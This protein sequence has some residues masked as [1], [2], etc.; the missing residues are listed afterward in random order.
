[1]GRHRLINIKST[2]LLL[3]LTVLMLLLASCG[4]GIQIANTPTF[5]VKDLAKVEVE[6]TPNATPTSTPTP[7]PLTTVIYT[8]VASTPRS[9]A[10]PHVQPP[11]T[12]VEASSEGN[13]LVISFSPETEARYRV[14]EQLAR[15]NLPNDAV[16]VTNAVT[17]VVTFDV[18]GKVVP[19]DSKIT[20]DASA[21]KSDEDRRDNRV[22]KDILQTNQFP[23]IDFVIK[24]TPGL[25]WPLL[26][27]GEGL[28]ELVGDLTIRDVTKEVTW[29]V[30]ATFISDRIRGLA[31]T[32]FTFDDF[33]ISKP[34][35]MFILSVEDLIRLEL[36]FVA[37]YP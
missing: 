28:F 13:R 26:G 20:I 30:G 6:P 24:K 3:L 14:K 27:S 33:E 18:E 31:E 15:L 7:T 11:V 17:G 12:P 5:E 32:S 2:L 34:T 25:T 16:G 1:M 22:R 21:L 36:A 23:T 10:T 29:S 19:K 37:T 35:G 8:P 4:G 9:L